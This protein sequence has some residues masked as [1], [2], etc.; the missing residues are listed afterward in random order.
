MVR[1]GSSYLSQ[2][3]LALTFG[4]GH[5]DRADRIVIYWPS[6]AVQD[7]KNVAPGEWTCVE[8]GGLAAKARA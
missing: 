7:F 5:H 8:G 1:T 2:S 3:E 4:L 6:G